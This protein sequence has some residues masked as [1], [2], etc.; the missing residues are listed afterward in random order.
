MVLESLISPREAAKRP[1][2]LFILGFI[3]ACVGVMLALWVFPAEAALS[4]V[5]LTSMAAIP[6]LYRAIIIEEREQVEIPRIPILKE[7]KDIVA[8]FLF[9]FLGMLFGFTLW[10]VAMPQE[11]NAG[12]FSNQIDT[13]NQV[14]QQFGPSG[15]AVAPDLAL[16]IIITN[17]FRVMAF[18]LL[19]SFLYGAGAIFILTWNASVLGTAIGNAIKVNLVQTSS[20]L[21]AIPLSLGQYLIHGLPE[22]IAY[23]LAAIAGGIISTSIVRKR[24][25]TKKWKIIIYDS[26]ALITL[27]CV[28]III[29]GVMEVMFAQVWW[30]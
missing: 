30:S 11:I 23:F 26:L 7:H 18:C 3:Y 14:S 19:F 15:S 21:E 22:I 20:Y 29:G 28:L 9:L 12:L 5:F 17:N 10:Y 6:F 27:S 1:V 4:M 8:Y 2:I 24:Y 13:I 25:K 16:R